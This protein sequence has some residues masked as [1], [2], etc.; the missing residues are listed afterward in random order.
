[1]PLLACL[2]AAV[3]G[4]LVVDDY[5]VAT[6]EADRREIAVRAVDYVLGKNDDMLH[7][8]DRVMGVAFELPLYLVE[9][10]LGLD[11]SRSIFLGRHLL[12]HWFF[13]VGAFFCGLLTHRLTGSRAAAVLGTLLFLLH[14]RLYAHS[15]FNTKDIPFASMFMI[16][17]YAAWR[18]FD[19]DAWRSFAVAG[20]AAGV[21][22]SM[23]IM[24]LALVAGVFAVQI[25][26]LAL[27]SQGPAAKRRL[28]SVGAFLA[29]TALVVFATWPYL[30]ADPVA[31]FAESVGTAANHPS[32]VVQLVAGQGAPAY[33]LPAGYLPAWFAATTPPVA[34]FFG[35]VGI[36]V[37]LARSARRPGEALRNG[38][39][40]FQALVVGCLVLPVLA[41]VALRPTLFDGWRHLYFIY[42]PFAVLAAVGVHASASW[43][44]SAKARTA[45]YGATGIGLLA[46][47]A[48]MARLHPYQHVYFNAFVDKEGA[49]RLAEQYDLDY[50]FTSYREGF[51]FLLSR[52][53][54]HRIHVAGSFEQSMRLN[55]AILR[56]EQRERLAIGEERAEF[57]VDVTYGRGSPDWRPV[58]GPVLY[59][60]RRYNSTI[61]QVAA[62]ELADAAA[63]EPYRL[64]YE[65]VSRGTPAVR[66]AYDVYVVDDGLAYLKEPCDATD[67]GDVLGVYVTPA[68]IGDLPPHLHL[69]GYLGRAYP[70]GRF[71]V[72]FGDRCLIRVPLPRFPVASVRTGTQDDGRPIWEATF[73]PGTRGREDARTEGRRR[74]RAPG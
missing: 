28:A 54:E 57:F 24:G 47:C 38:P 4:A 21:L 6:D 64:A 70:F 48:S 56:P 14:P 53:P 49:E 5:G 72:R 44:R 31:R 71:G 8:F 62:V 42:A 22:V 32:E 20:A 58:A 65:T 61:M 23:R 74:A 36:L 50:W 46:V 52:H 7:H 45:V 59:S 29:A 12:S 41:V 37:I 66:S 68:D 63:S 9:L 26:D 10:A 33:D 1:M 69:Y 27:A 17:L 55:R 11:D 67:T 3:V 19:R 16:C 39:L 18:A 2:A 25:C 15:F 30:W 60:S 34:L 13:L 43:S 40:R 35:L 73:E 51:E